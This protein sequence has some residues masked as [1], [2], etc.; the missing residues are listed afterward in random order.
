MAINP[1]I[2]DIFEAAVVVEKCQSIFDHCDQ[3]RHAELA[4][5]LTGLPHLGEMPI[6]DAVRLDLLGL[7]SKD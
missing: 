3:S 2:N 1:F 6:D 5:Q 7:I 4:S